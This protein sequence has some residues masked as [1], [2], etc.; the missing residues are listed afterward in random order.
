M[1]GLQ[2]A[3]RMTETEYLFIN[4]SIYRW[5]IGVVG[6]IQVKSHGLSKRIHQALKKAPVPAHQAQSKNKKYPGKDIIQ[7]DPT[8]KTANPD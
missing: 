5:R 6:V 7:T 3:K 2:T 8:T 4:L 1:T